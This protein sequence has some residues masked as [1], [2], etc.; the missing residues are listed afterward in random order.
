M[1]NRPLGPPPW[2]GGQ[3]V[4]WKPHPVDSMSD[5]G[6]GKGTSTVCQALLAQVQAATAPQ[7]I[8]N[9]GTEAVPRIVEEQAQTQGPS[10]QQQLSEQEQDELHEAMLVQHL[11]QVYEAELAEKVY[12]DMER[13][14]L[15]AQAIEE[16]QQEGCSSMSSQSPSDHRPAV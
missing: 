1:S 9:V 5:K 14:Q 7:S 4:Y 15:I 12:M 10:M 16:A 11:A 2:S 6:K 13:E 3:V 8:S